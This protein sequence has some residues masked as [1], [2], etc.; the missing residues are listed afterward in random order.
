MGTGR[1]RRSGRAGA[2]ARPRFRCRFWWRAPT[3]FPPASESDRSSLRFPDRETPTRSIMPPRLRLTRG[4]RLVVVSVGGWLVDF[5]QDRG[6][7]LVRIPPDIQPARVDL[8]RGG[9][10]AADDARERR[11]SCPRRELGLKA[12]SLSCAGVAKS[13]VGTTMSP[14]VSLRCWSAGTC[15]AR[16]TRPS[17]PRQPNDGRHRSIRMQGR[18]L[19][20]RSSRTPATTKRSPGIAATTSPCSAMR[21]CCCD[22]GMKIP[23]SANASIGWRTI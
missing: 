22:M 16:E 13:F 17:A 5:A 9:R 11:L 18:L 12:P 4:A 10:L 15:C 23:G 19:P 7:A 8:R 1:I 2:S 3:K 6:A 21:R 20:H 14:S